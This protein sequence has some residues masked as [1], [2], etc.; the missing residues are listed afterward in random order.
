MGDGG[1][2]GQRDTVP[3]R[4]AEQVQP[5]GAILRFAQRRGSGTPGSGSTG[6]QGASGSLANRSEDPTTGG[7]ALEEQPDAESNIREHTLAGSGDG[8]QTLPAS[9]QGTPRRITR[10]AAQALARQSS[11]AGGASMWQGMFCTACQNTR[12]CSRGSG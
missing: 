3:Q 8:Q 12:K 10:S 11:A 7:A 6:L 9:D 2:N 4:Q 5:Q 1:Q